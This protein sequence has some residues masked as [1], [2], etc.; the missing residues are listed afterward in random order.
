MPRQLQ[1]AKQPETM[2][3][4]LVRLHGEANEHATGPD[5]LREELTGHT[6]KQERNIPNCANRKSSKSKFR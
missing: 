4:R 1:L 5:E 3:P 6:H 2:Q